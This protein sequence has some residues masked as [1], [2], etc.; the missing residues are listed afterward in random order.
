MK[1][2]WDKAASEAHSSVFVAD[3]NCS[4][5]E[6]LCSKEGVQGYPTIKV[7]K[8]GS[9]TDYKGGRSAEELIEYV[10][11]ELAAKC[12][13][14][15]A[16]NSGCSEKAIAYIQKW[17]DKDDAAAAKKELDR[18]TGMLKSSMKADLKQWLSERINILN[19][20]G[21]KSGDEL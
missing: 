20:L 6:E 5:Q 7:Y 10:D 2:A 15:D 8:D 21:S 14:K 13:V 1:P 19:Q 3:I 16:A 17:T 4:D 9:V 12:D 18:L 11:Q